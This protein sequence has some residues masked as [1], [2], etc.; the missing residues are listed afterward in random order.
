LQDVLTQYYPDT[1]AASPIAIV[2]HRKSDAVILG[3]DVKNYTLVC[4]WPCR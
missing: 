4:H 3:D 2:L 1:A